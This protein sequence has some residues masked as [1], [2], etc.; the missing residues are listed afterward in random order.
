MCSSRR[1]CLTFLVFFILKLC[2]LFKAVFSSGL[3]QGQPSTTS[4]LHQL[5]NIHTLCSPCLHPFYI[6]H[7]L[8]VSSFQAFYMQLFK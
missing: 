6:L 7:T 5:Y 2:N 3:P 4:I 8:Y 1:V